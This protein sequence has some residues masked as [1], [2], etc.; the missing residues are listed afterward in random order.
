MCRVGVD[1]F[2]TAA[3]QPSRNNELIHGHRFLP[4]EPVQVAFRNAVQVCNL[5][6]TERGVSE[7]LLNVTDDFASLP[8]AKTL[9][10]LPLCAGCTQHK[11]VHRIQYDRRLNVGIVK[12]SIGDSANQVI[13]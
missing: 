4:K 13:Q 8:L 11:G 10:R 5:S 1:E 2:F 12:I 7:V 9:I 6:D 3:L